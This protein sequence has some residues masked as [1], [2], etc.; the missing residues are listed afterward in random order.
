MSDPH[1]I[2]GPGGVCQT[3]AALKIA[4]GGELPECRACLDACRTCAGYICR[5]QWPRIKIPKKRFRT[6]QD[7]GAKSPPKRTTSRRIP[8]SPLNSQGTRREQVPGSL[9]P[10]GRCQQENSLLQH[11]AKNIA[12]MALALDYEGN[13]YRSFLPIAMADD[14]LLNAILAASSSHLS[15]LQSTPDHSA[16]YMKQAL[17]HLDKRLSDPPLASSTATLATI[18]SLISLEDGRGSSTWKHHYEGLSGWLQSTSGVVKLDPFIKSWVYMATYQAAMVFERRP[19]NI[20]L[21]WLDS[22]ERLHDLTQ[23]ID[24]FLG[25]SVKLPRLLLRAAT[26][27]IERLTTDL[28][29]VELRRRSEELQQEIAT[30][31]IDIAKPLKLAS[32]FRTEGFSTVDLISEGRSD[33]WRRAGATAEIFRHAAH[34]YVHRIGSPFSHELPPEVEQSVLSI[35]DLLDYVPDARGPGSNLSWPL[36]IVGQE[37]HSTELRD[38]LLERWQS[39]HLLGMKSTHSTEKVLVEMWKNHDSAKTGSCVAVRWQHMMHQ[40]GIVPMLA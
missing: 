13:I 22:T 29:E 25:Y 32:S 26:L 10:F 40:M 12:T 28:C 15:R 4:C 20:I 35:F 31:E 1:S 33:L 38:L 5:P 17:T 21:E 7:H 30:C 14:A 8:S 34:I 36:F 18:L 3:C 9:S 19:S 16:R 39:L 37:T 23:A 24:P 2:L 11:Y 6:V 27:H